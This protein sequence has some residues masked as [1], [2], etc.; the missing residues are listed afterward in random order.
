MPC[1]EYKYTRMDGTVV[2]VERSNVPMRQSQEPI[3]VLDDG[4][5]YAAE[6]V[7]SLTA[8]MKVS[9]NVDL[10]AGDLPPVKASTEDV[11]RM[12]QK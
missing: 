4:E 7:I 2:T 1:Y 11:R 8:D 10:N 3:M 9:W 6:R 12:F 5:V